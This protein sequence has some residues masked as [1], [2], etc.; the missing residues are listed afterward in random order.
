M[1]RLNWTFLLLC[2]VLPSV[3]S[4]RQVKAADS[5][6]G[7]RESIAGAQHETQINSRRDSDP[8]QRGYRRDDRDED[9]TFFSRLLSSLLFGND[10]TNDRWH[11]SRRQKT[12]TKGLGT[13]AGNVVTNTFL[14]PVTAPKLLVNDRGEY[15]NFS[16]YP[17]ADDTANMLLTPHAKKN[18]KL[19]RTRLLTEYSDNFDRQQKITTRILLDTRFRLG[20]DASF[21]YLRE[22]LGGSS[23]DQTWLGDCNFVYRFAQSEKVE[24]RT[25]MGFAWQSDS[26]GS[27]TGINFT[28]GGN[29]YLGKPHMIDFDLDLGRVGSAGLTRFRTGYS[30]YFYRVRATLGYEYLKVGSFD[31]SYMSSGVGIDF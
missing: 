18:R 8:E 2:I 9:E 5:L 17:Y 12:K 15:A 13:L 6:S 29:Y 30:L 19:L 20:L 27:D 31:A 3:M 25:G 11:G 14:L 16:V 7:M 23:H 22:Q 10:N 1:V 28:Y 21:D 24:F 26:L 4:T